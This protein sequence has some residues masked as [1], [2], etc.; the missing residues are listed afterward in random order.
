[1]QNLRVPDGARKRKQ[2]VGR[3]SGSGRGGYSGRGR[4]GQNARSGGGVR[5]GFEG[6]QMPLYRRIARRGFSNADFREEY[7]TINICDFVGR[8]DDGDTVTL[9]SLK[10]KKVLK[11]GVTKV[12]VLGNGE[13]DKKLMIQVDMVSAG[14]KAKIEKAGGKVTGIEEGNDGK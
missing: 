2:I 9:E 7:E 6:G 13:I 1:M 4:N 11:Q 5:L 12:K 10:E 3:G 8:F 14:A